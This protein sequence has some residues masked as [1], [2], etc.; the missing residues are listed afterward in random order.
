MAGS[1]GLKA[2]NKYPLKVGSN[3]LTGA[4]AKSI[5]IAS[6]NIVADPEYEIEIEGLTVEATANQTPFEATSLVAGGLFFVS[7]SW[8]KQKLAYNSRLQIMQFIERVIQTKQA[9]IITAAQVNA[10]SWKNISRERLTEEQASI[11]I[12]ASENAKQDMNMM[13]DLLQMGSDTNSTKQGMF[14][15]KR[16]KETGYLTDDIRAGLK[17]E[18]IDLK[19]YSKLLARI[20][21]SNEFFAELKTGVDRWGIKTNV[22]INE[23]T[24]RSTI[25]QADDILG[26]RKVL[27]EQQLIVD[28]MI[29]TGADSLIEQ[30]MLQ[31]YDFDNY[32][33]EGKYLNNMSRDAERNL[34]SV[35]Q[36]AEDLSKVFDNYYMENGIDPATMKPYKIGEYNPILG[37]V[38]K[39]TKLKG[40]AKLLGRGLSKFFFWDGILWIGTTIIDI[41]LN[42]FMAEEEQGFFS[43]RVGFSVV[44]EFLIIP[45]VDYIFPKEKQLEYLTEALTKIAESN[46]TLEGAVFATLLYFVEELNMSLSFN[47]DP[48]TTGIALYDS[49]PPFDPYNI[50]IGAWGLIVIAELWR[51]LLVPAYNAI[52]S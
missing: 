13:Q 48:T 28:R 16:V 26:F 7:I 10:S 14:F 21:E 6:T 9:S 2:L 3:F 36:S 20:V 41:S 8:A 43:D 15:N 30:S 47:I 44:D 51:S 38:T 22:R 12:E 24:L 34:A 50:L 49:L 17:S 1:R 25:F 39:A 5:L 37:K 23:I 18:G 46:D 40:G 19:H 29:H 33:E 42:P 11:M 45:L 35:T 4:I 31:R 32:S 27:Q 52:L